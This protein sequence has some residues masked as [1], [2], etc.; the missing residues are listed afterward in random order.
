MAIADI[1]KIRLKKLEQIKKAG[2]NPYPIKTRKTHSVEQVLG[3]F[4]K[5]SA[6]KTEIALAGRIVA[7]REHGGSCFINIDDGKVKIQGFFRQDKL[8]DKKYQFFLDNFDVG[9]FIE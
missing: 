1:K 7:V 8:G 5:L 6:A 4:D 9:D 3:E 2:I